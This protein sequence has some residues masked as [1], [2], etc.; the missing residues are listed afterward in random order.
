MPDVVL[1]MF[2]G[3][4]RAAVARLPAHEFLYS[5]RNDMF[6]GRYCGLDKNVSLQVQVLSTHT[7]TVDGAGERFS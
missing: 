1:S 5:E 3:D 4:K 6:V 7:S 2:V